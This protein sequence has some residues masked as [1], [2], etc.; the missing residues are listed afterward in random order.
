MYLKSTQYLTCLVNLINSS[1]FSLIDL[2]TERVQHRSVI[3]ALK[4][5]MAESDLVSDI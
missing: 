5:V 4:T 2:I 3:E 1:K